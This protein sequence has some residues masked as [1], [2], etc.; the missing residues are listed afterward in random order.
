MQVPLK[1]AIWIIIGITILVS[2]SATLGL[3]YYKY[4][5]QQRLHDSK[6]AIKAIVQASLEKEPL[7]TAYFA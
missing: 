1:K 2:G 3:F 6:Y 5:K 4:I 7:K